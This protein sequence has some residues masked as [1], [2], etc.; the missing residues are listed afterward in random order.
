MALVDGTIGKAP[1]A[2]KIMITVMGMV[3]PMGMTKTGTKAITVMAMAT[4]IRRCA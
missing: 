1:G 3:T 2:G 4:T